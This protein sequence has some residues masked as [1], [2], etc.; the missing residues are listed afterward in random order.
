MW[1][2]LVALAA[3]GVAGSLWAEPIGAVGS[4]STHR[5]GAVEEREENEHRPRHGGFF[6]DAD[7]LY[8]YEVLLEPGSRLVLYVNDEHNRP[9]DVRAL[10]GRW[11][12]NPDH[13]VPMSGALTPSEDGAYFLALLPSI[14]ADPIHVKVAVPKGA[15]LA[16]MEFYLPAS[17][18]PSFQ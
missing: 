18:S 13:P 15:A 17:R 16:E 5:H 8:H 7:D 1:A 11:T 10:E 14:S 9:L 3:V 6:G 2:L 12:L 4:P